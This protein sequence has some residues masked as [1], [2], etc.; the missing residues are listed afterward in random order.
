MQG[1]HFEQA[2][3]I[4]NDADQSLS[5]KHNLVYDIV[6]RVKARHQ[7]VRAQCREFKGMELELAEELRD[8]EALFESVQRAKKRDEA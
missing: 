4:L 6:Q 7:T 8:V 1:R 3:N 5:S 2:W